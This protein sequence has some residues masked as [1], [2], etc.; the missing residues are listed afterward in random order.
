MIKHTC[1]FAFLLCLFFTAAGVQ[2]QGELDAYA[3]KTYVKG[4]DT[5]PYRILY[6]KNFDPARKY[7]LVLVLHGAGERGDDNQKQLVYGAK[8]F[9]EE[10]EQF[11]AIVVFPQCP[12]DSYWSNVDIVKDEAGKRTFNFQEK[13]KP[14]EAMRSLMGLLK[15]LE[16]SGSIDKERMYLGGLSMGGMGTFELL[17]RKPNTFAAAFPICGGGH[18][19][20]AR[21]YAKK[22]DLWVFHGEDDSVVPVEKSRIMAAAL[23]DAG[24]D[25]QLTIYP[26]VNHN[27][28][29][30]AFKEPAL[31][32]WLFSHQ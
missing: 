2:A 27:S 14:T 21:K 16:K 31:L 1:F 26:G 5:L 12:T 29:D 15:Q 10:Q 9:L 20:T 4:N 28:W 22:V 32:E 3:R 7:P 25:V 17:R 18:P 24:G 23:E 6:P 8:R 13:G 30:Y 11:P 19:A